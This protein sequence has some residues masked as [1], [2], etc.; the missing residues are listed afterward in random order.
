M[1][2]VEHDD[3]LVDILTDIV[4][5]SPPPLPH[6]VNSAFAFRDDT[7]VNVLS[8]IE[9]P[10]SPDSWRGFTDDSQQGSLTGNVPGPPTH[11]LDMLDDAMVDVLTDISVPL[12][13]AISDSDSYSLDDQGDNAMVDTLMGIRIPSPPP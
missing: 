10:E 8:D 7:M 1:T 4:L 11:P 5:L 6:P 2:L 12:P 3:A 13:P 9:I